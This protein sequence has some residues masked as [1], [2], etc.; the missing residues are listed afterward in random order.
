MK[1]LSKYQVFFENRKNESILESFG[2]LLEADEAAAAAPAQ[3]QSEK[4]IL[5]ET[6]EDKKK[7]LE[8]I[9]GKYFPDTKGKVDVDTAP[10]EGGEP[11]KEGEAKKEGEEV[12]KKAVEGEEV[13]KK[14]GE[15]GEK[16]NE[17]AVLLAIT[18]ASLLPAVMEAAGSLTNLLKQKYGI[19]L[20]E[21]QMAS[22]KKINDG[23]TAYNKLLKDPKAT[24]KFEKKPYTRENWEEISNVLSTELALPDLAFGKGY[25]AHGHHAPAAKPAEGEKVEDKKEEPAVAAKVAESAEA[26]EVAKKGDEAT[27][28]IK[29][30]IEK[31]KS[32]RDKVFGAKFGNWLKEKG[33]GLHSVYTSPIRLVLRGIAKFSKKSSKLRDE[34]TREKIANVLYA[35]TMI[36][37]AGYGIMST[38]NHMAGVGEVAQILLKGTESGIQLSELRKQALTAILGA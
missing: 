8:D 15:E 33:H 19:N 26:P 28:Q 25:D 13:E 9:L 24:V 4:E 22:V 5:D 3:S 7:K 14:E 32:Q 30:E 29:R 18:I 34:A 21:K 31:L 35:I 38:L 27:D 1:R 23:I 17:G 11:A 10:N 16:T 2:M 37:L 20:D 12:E 36:S 6:P